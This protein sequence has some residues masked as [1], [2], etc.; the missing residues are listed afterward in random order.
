MLGR[1]ANE[2]E[3]RV[4]DAELMELGSDP[5]SPVPRVRYWMGV[6]QSNL[7]DSLVSMGR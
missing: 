3:N 6:P 5:N 1:L 7:D 4:A 2:N